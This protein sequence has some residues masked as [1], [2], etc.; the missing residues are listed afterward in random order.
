[1]HPIW[2][3]LRN[4]HDDF[5][6]THAWKHITALFSLSANAFIQIMIEMQ[7]EYP[8]GVKPIF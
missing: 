6:K 3:K 5:L 7:R 1:M 8:L 4:S 2:V